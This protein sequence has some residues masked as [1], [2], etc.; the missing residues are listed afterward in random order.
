MVDGGGT[1]TT[2]S[3]RWSL[4]IA[5]QYWQHFNS[6]YFCEKYFLIRENIN[7]GYKPGGCTKWC[8]NNNNMTKLPKKMVNLQWTARIVISIIE[9]SLHFPTSD[10]FRV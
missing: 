10:S 1:D 3:L 8:S 5:C 6:K 2:F 7:S 4:A 9:S